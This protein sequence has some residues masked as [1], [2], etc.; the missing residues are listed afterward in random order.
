M[1]K[2]LATSATLVA[3]AATTF[4][5]GCS[6]DE[7]SATGGALGGQLVVTAS[8][9][10]LGANGY[11]FPPSP[12][13]EV[14]FVDGWEVK[15]DKIIAVVGSVTVS[16]DPDTN[17]GD[18]GQVGA[19]VASQA[20]PWAVNLTS[21]GNEED[22]GGAGKVAVRLPVEF[23]DI[24]DLE[25]RYAF[26][27]ALAAASDTTTL[28]NVAEGDAD[29]AKMKQEGWVALVTGTATFKGTDCKSSDPAYDFSAYPT[30]VKFT[31]GFHNP[32]VYENC[33]NPDN[34]GEA[35]PGEESQ[36][37]IQVL[38]NAPTLAQI[39]IHT[40]HL[41][42]ATVEHD[43]V[44][45]FN[46]FASHAVEQGGAW[47]VDL[48]MFESVPLTPVT[49]AQGTA[50]PWRSCVSEALYTLPTTP[51][52]MTFDTGGQDLDNL[53]DFVGFNGATMGHLNADGLCHVDGFEHSHTHE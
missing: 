1:N 51:S 50:I 17:P 38:P 39:T 10:S 13:Q 31:F 6:S 5:A 18:Q 4:F 11:A 7:T 49:D 28:V 21:G 32:I 19:V 8:A 37:G 22:K 35:L 29:F 25:R 53:H 12:G 2:H 48:E 45:M 24:F 16:E 44:P 52:Q 41:F 42:W 30:V 34:T 3:L 47:T 46:Q 27:F 20:G 14:A 33:Q 15:F 23:K 36:R 40:D 26:G 9:E 43:A